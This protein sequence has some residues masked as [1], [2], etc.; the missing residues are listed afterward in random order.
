[1]DTY[2]AIKINIGK[3]DKTFNNKINKMESNVNITTG[4]INTINKVG[5]ILGYIKKNDLGDKIWYSTYISG[6]LVWYIKKDFK[7]EYDV[8]LPLHFKFNFRV[9]N[10]DTKQQ[11]E[12]DEEFEL[13]AAEVEKIILEKDNSNI[14]HKITLKDNRDTETIKT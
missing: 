1:M 12:K 4:E 3:I 9:Y 10:L 11:G 2:N 6:K 14:S 7:K 13:T 8:V 5:Y